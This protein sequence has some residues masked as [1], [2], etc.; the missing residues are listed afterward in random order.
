MEVWI[1]TEND[2]FVEGNCIICLK[3]HVTAQSQSSE[4]QIYEDLMMTK[5]YDDR[6]LFTQFTNH[7]FTWF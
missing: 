2:S 3:E 4:R 5:V 7:K 1:K 6:N